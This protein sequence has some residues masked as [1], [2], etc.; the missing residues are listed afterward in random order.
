LKV[1]KL[2]GPMS[3]ESVSRESRKNST[4]NRMDISSTLILRPLSKLEIYKLYDMLAPYL[5]HEP[6][7]AL[8]LPAE[9]D[10]DKLM[11]RK[12]GTSNQICSFILTLPGPASSQFWLNL[13]ADTI[14]K[15]LPSRA[16]SPDL[17]TS[18]MRENA[19]VV[20]RTGRHSS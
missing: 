14:E 18:S 6:S 4:S 20:G 8:H 11:C 2:P 1:I 5:C 12:L 3:G 7:A 16:A 9:R 15:L 17:C 13:I 10:A 19:A